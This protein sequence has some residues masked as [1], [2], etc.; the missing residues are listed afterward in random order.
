MVGILRKNLLKMFIQYVVYYRLYN[1]K[2]VVIWNK[3]GAFISNCISEVGVIKMMLSN[4]NSND[5]KCLMFI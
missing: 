2:K 3:I 1:D 4:G 5:K